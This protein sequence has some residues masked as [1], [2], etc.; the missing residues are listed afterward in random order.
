MNNHQDTIEKIC[1]LTGDNFKGII[2]MLSYIRNPANKLMNGILADR[3]A[4][5]WLLGWLSEKETLIAVFGRDFAYKDNNNKMVFNWQ[6]H[7]NQQAGF[8]AEERLIYIEK[9]WEEKK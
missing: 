9:Y 5:I 4:Y 3:L 6:Y 8:T 2:A 1:E 7:S